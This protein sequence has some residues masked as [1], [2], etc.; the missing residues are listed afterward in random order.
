[1]DETNADVGDTANDNVRINANELNVKVVGEGG[2]LGFTQKARI[3][4]AINGGKIYTDAL[5]NS[6]CVD[7]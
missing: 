5:D 1:M 2:N 3:S 4:F 6:A 7:M